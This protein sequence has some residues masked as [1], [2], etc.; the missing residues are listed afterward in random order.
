MALVAL[1]AQRRERQWVIYA[2]VP[3]EMPGLS[4]MLSALPA[5]E[6]GGLLDTTPIADDRSQPPWGRIRLPQGY[7]FTSGILF[8]AIGHNPQVESYTL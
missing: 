5:P 1:V 3:L 4:E 2:P 6:S 7:L 8:Q